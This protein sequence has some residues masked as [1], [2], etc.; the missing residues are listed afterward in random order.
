MLQPQD[1][2]EQGITGEVQHCHYQIPAMRQ[3]YIQIT[4]CTRK[5]TILDYD[6]E[7]GREN[8]MMVNNFLPCYKAKWLQYPNYPPDHIPKIVTFGCSFHHFIPQAYTA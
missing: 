7:R 1:Q 2:S 5:G 6:R 8:E 4:I 3:R